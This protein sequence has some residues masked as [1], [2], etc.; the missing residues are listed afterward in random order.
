VERGFRAMGTELTPVHSYTNFNCTLCGQCLQGCPT[1]SGQSTMTAYIHPSRAK[2]GL[3]LRANCTVTR[4]VME[5]RG[6]RLRATG[7]EYLDAS[8]TP[9][10]VDAQVVVVAAGTL[11][12][13]QLLLR[14]DIV[15]LARGS[16]SSRLVGKNLG[17]HTG[18]FV[19]GYFDEPQD[20]HM[21]Y[22]LT[23]H[24]TRFQRDEDGGFLV[25]ACSIMDPIALGSNLVDENMIPLWGQRLAD[26]M[27][28]YRNWAGLFMMTNDTNN[29][30]VS[31][32]PDGQEKFEKPIPPPD[33]DKLTNGFNFCSEVLRA[34]G[35][36]KI[37]ATGYLTS[38]VQGTCRMGSDPRRSVVNSHGESHDVQGLFIGDGSVI[39]RTL[40]VN[41][42]LT[43]MALATRMADHIHQDT[44]GCFR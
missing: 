26:T 14:S 40:S 13:P 34:A 8:G 22:P 42:S 16:A 27:K 11:N 17:T 15:E 4:V 23:A 21:V 12:T 24:C 36:T 43:I 38:H 29:G 1:N 7:V 18:R 41:P 19:H 30:T 44:S 6:S 31:I 20:N 10:R 25:E 28:E 35:A 2:D 9:Q 39:P 33:A 5:K 32:G 3:D 37:A